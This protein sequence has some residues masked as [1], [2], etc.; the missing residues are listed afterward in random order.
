MSGIRDLSV[1]ETAPQERKPVATAVLRRDTEHLRR[2]LQRELER[3]GQVFWVYN[4]V[5]GLDRVRDYVRS[6]VPDARIGMAHGQMGEVELEENM[7]KFWHGD[8][9]ILV[10]TSIVESGLDF[11]RANT[12][13]VD[14]AQM[15]GLGQLY[16]L[17]GRVG[18]SDRQAYAF[19]IVPDEDRLT[20]L[21]EERLRIVMD[22]DYLGA[23]FQ[24]ALE[25]LRLRGA[26]NILGEVQSGHMT[27]VG[28]D[29]YLEMLEE[30]VARLKGT[31]TALET[32]TELNLGLPA[33]IP[34]TYID[35]GRERLRC[36]KA[37]TSAPSG[38]AREEA[39]LAMRDRFGPYPPEVANFLAVLDFKQ[40]LCSLQ[41]QRA[42][43]SPDHVRLTW[44]EGQRAV[45]PERLVA[46]AAATPGARLLPP[47][48][49]LLPLPEGDAGAGLRVLREKLESARRASGDAGAQA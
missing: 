24:V 28:L 13:I 41:V 11:P 19:F 6:L 3:E 44:A 49:L 33:H 30:A 17:R 47:A 8:L 26:G 46:L 23:G 34:Q 43:I 27:R 38:A 31:P 15:F 22:M 4:R 37:L 45:A 10:C 39:A 14:Q 20:P 32:E 35:D 29:L 7:H 48:G 40:F 21:A 9:D 2:I 18:R 1:I 42:D 25:D 5:Q 36:Y 16:Q 12:L